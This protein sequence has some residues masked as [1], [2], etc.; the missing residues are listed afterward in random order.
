[1]AEIKDLLEWYK[2]EREERRQR[3]KQEEE[4]RRQR[5]KQEQER[6]QRE[7]Q[8]EQER[9]QRENKRGDSNKV[10][11]AETKNKLMNDHLIEKFRQMDSKCRQM[12]TKFGQISNQIEIWRKEVMS[13][14]AKPVDLSPVKVQ[15][16]GTL[17]HYKVPKYDR[18]SSWDLYRKQFEVGAGTA[19]QSSRNTPEHPEE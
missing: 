15:P 6:G 7:K 12:N 2:A 8:E 16:N 1:M 10:K 14:C 11:N 4:E 9:R 17:K 3:E 18:K 5:E 19:S 13:I